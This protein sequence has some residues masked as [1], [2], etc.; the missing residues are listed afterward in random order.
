MTYRPRC[1]EIEV[2][3]VQGRFERGSELS[4]NLLPVQPGGLGPMFGV[5]EM[6]VALGFCVVYIGDPI[7][8]A[9]SGGEH[10]LILR[11]EG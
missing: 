5:R 4:V 11:T 6:D 9:G 7:L 2:A 8:S 10:S 1:R 3:I